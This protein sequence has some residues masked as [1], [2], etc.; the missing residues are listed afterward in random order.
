MQVAGGF[1]RLRVPARCYLKGTDMTTNYDPGLS[2]TLAAVCELTYKQYHNGP[3]PGNDGSITPPPGYTQTSKFTA[4]ELDFSN[5]KHLERFKSIDTATLGSDDSDALRKAAIGLQDVYFGFTLT[6]ATNNIIA[7]RGTKNMFE[8]IMDATI[9]QVPIP[10]VWYSHDKL[11]TAKAHLGF[12]I[13]LAFL[14]EQILDAAKQFDTSLPCYVTGHSL[15]AALAALAPVPVL[16]LTDNKDVQMYN[17]AGPRV[18]DQIYA[19]AYN[20]LIPRSYRV[21]NLSDLVPMLPPSE[22]LKWTYAH[23]GTEWSFLNQS[24]NVGGNHALTGPDN[25]TDAVVNEIPTD[26]PRKYPV[27]GL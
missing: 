26:A 16:L 20:F 4:P 27:T 25:Y 22:I 17:Y 2:K 8:W 24:G 15:G 21:V 14:I 5:S 7:L 23:V 18:G 1:A 6:S 9:P 19:D 12:L 10:L 3:P 11:K 13:L